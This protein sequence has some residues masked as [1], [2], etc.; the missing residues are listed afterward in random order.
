MC[1]KEVSSH[2]LTT[3]QDGALPKTT[4]TVSLSHTQTWA[5]PSMLPV[6]PHK[7]K[8][9]YLSSNPSTAHTYLSHP[10]QRQLQLPEVP[11]GSA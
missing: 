9:S 5:M 2:T 10:T 7:P 11:A 8:H 1:F 4:H 6:L 3:S